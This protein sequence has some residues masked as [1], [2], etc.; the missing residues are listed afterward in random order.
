VENEPVTKEAIINGLWVIG[1]VVVFIA[2]FVLIMARSLRKRS[3]KTF[4]VQTKGITLPTRE[5]N[6]REWKVAGLK[7]RKGLYIKDKNLCPCGSGLQYKDCCG[8]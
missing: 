7:S 2:V 1:V 6:Y 5:R 3:K 4:T 8:K